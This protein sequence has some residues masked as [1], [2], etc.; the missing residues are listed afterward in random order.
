MNRKQNLKNYYDSLAIAISDSE[1]ADV[2]TSAWK[3]EL[4]FNNDSFTHENE[5]VY[6]ENT[7]N[8]LFW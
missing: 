5:E 6:E 2:S 8:A 7:L 3:Y 1:Y 4:D